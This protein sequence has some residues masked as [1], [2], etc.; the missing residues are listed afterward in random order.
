MIR[1]AIILALIEVDKTIVFPISTDVSWV[2]MVDGSMKLQG[3]FEGSKI[4]DEEFFKNHEV[5]LWGLEV[6]LDSLHKKYEFE[7]KCH[8]EEK[9]TI[10]VN[11]YFPFQD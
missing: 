3:T 8:I 5:I 4:G 2:P 9:D 1:Y 11:V 10:S 6:Y 7:R